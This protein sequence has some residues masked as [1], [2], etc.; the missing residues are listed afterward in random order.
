MR[1][2]A[3]LLPLLLAAPA[4]TQE[5]IPIFDTH[6]HYNWEPAPH[7][8]LDRV[9]AL[10]RD[11]G[12]VGIVATSR[13]N[14][15]TVALVEARPP[16]LQVVPFLR[17]YRVRADIQ[18][19]H[20]SPAT[21]TLIDEEFARG[22]YVGIGEFHLGGPFGAAPA[23]AATVAFARDHKLFLHAHADDEALEALFAQDP[24]A[25][26]IWAHTGFSTPTA[27]I[28]AYLDRHAGL[29]CEL[30]YRGGITDGGGRLTPEWRALFERYPDRFLLGS[31]TWIS[32]RWDG[33]GAIMA[34]YRGWLAQLPRPVAEQIAYRN[35]T[36]LFAKAPG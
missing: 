3:L 19:W 9:L 1:L 29:W 31:D 11:N 21:A 34:E 25:R 36:R 2:L 33:Y 6:L 13:P 15:G 27:K 10:F 35:A 23:V 26:I 12:I 7:L 8:P 24:A 32:P 17:P 5:R 20:S 16:G 18:T 30:S 4:W 22:F 28:A 14:A